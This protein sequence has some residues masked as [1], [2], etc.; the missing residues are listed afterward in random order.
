MCHRW[1]WKFAFFEPSAPCKRLFEKGFVLD[2]REIL[3]VDKMKAPVC[4]GD[5]S[6]QV[7]RR[8]IFTASEGCSRVVHANKTQHRKERKDF[9]WKPLI[10]KNHREEEELHYNSQMTWITGIW[11]CQESKFKSLKRYSGKCPIP[12]SF[13]HWRWSTYPWV[14]W[15]WRTTVM[16]E[17][18]VI[19]RLAHCNGRD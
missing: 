1:G 8:S 4:G 2:D 18:F 7:I 16:S 6:P 3:S 17:V 10:G 9:T 11:G 13:S 5:F 12:S 19:A 14:G 15:A